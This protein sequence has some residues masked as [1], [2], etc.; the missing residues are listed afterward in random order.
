MTNVA[1]A[2][3]VPG[4]TQPPAA[5]SIRG[6]LAADGDRPPPVRHAGR[7]DRDPG[8]LPHPERRQVHLAD[9]HG[10]AGRPGHRHRDH[11]DRHG[12]GHRVAQHRPVGRVARR[13]HRHGLRP[14]DDRLAAGARARRR[15]PVPVG[16]RPGRR[17]RPRRRRSAA[18][19]ASSS[20]TSACRRS[21]SPW[22]AC[23]RSAASVCYLSS[24]AA[25][26]GLDPSFQKIGG[27]AQGS[28]GG[29][30]TWVLGIIGCV[31]IV[32]PARQQPAP[33]PAATASRSG[34]CGR[35]SCSAVVGC[36]IVLGVRRNAILAEP[37]QR[38]LEHRSPD[39]RRG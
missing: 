27:G 16:H 32:A 17:A 35:R 19:R 39:R 1:D 4:Q 7:P 15:L 5:T 34:R 14:A 10:H 25:V 8:R 30:L 2:T 11:R 38:S 26:S 33:A 23:C 12:A 37:R 28:I 6:L 3:P 36:A 29:P 13:P 20:P 24:G 22:A 18:S 21:S 9:E 31:A